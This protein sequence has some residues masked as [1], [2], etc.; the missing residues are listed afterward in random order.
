M[1]RYICFNPLW[2][3]DLEAEVDARQ[4]VRMYDVSS[5]GLSDNLGTPAR[6]CW[7]ATLPAHVVDLASNGSIV[8]CAYARLTENDTPTLPDAGE[9]GVELRCAET[10]EFLR[11]IGELAGVDDVIFLDITRFHCLVVRASDAGQLV[12]VVDL[13]SARIVYEVD[14]KLSFTRTFGGIHIS[15]DETFMLL[16]S[17]SNHLAVIDLLRGTWTLHAHVEVD[18]EMLESWPYGVWFCR[19]HPDAGFEERRYTVGWKAIG[20]LPPASARMFAVM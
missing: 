16:W 9:F 12:T 3:D 19:E 8:A 18:E 17:S 11:T 14:L 20:G 13:Q 6:I 15:D 5:E 1:N 7:N 2:S 10:G 4:T